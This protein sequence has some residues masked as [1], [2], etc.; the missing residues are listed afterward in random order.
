MMLISQAHWLQ[1]PRLQ[2]IIAEVK[3]VDRGGSGKGEVERG[4][5]ESATIFIHIYNTKS[6]IVVLGK[7]IGNRSR[8]SSL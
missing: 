5:E 3:D 6:F 4:E 7:A 2:H 1:Q 8:K